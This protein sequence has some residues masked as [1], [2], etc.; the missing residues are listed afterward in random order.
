MTASHSF[1]ACSLCYLYRTRNCFSSCNQFASALGAA[2]RTKMQKQFSSPRNPD[3]R[4]A[5][6]GS[7]Y[8]GLYRGALLFYPVFR[9]MCTRN[10]FPVCCR[11]RPRSAYRDIRFYEKRAVVMRLVFLSICRCDVLC[12]L[13][14]DSDIRDCNLISGDCGIDHFVSVVDFCGRLDGYAAVFG[15]HRD[16]VVLTF[17]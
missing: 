8:A 16:D 15:A 7:E 11:L 9:G 5:N 6:K 3:G 4:S 10:Q 17:K 14:F 2:A 1:V 12:D 13:L